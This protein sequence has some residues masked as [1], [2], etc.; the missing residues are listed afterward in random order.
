MSDYLNT[1]QSLSTE[2]ERK[3]TSINDSCIK[4]CI[5]TYLGMSIMDSD[6]KD[7]TLVYHTGNFMKVDIMHLDRKIGTLETTF[8]T[9]WNNHGSNKII[10][11]T[12]FKQII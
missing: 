7:F 1:L 4:Q 5:E 2:F 11:T 3:I 8:G 12:V 10:A 9:D 6:L